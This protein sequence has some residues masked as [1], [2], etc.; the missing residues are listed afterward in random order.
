M[1]GPILRAK[2]GYSLQPVQTRDEDLICDW[3]NDPTHSHLFLGDGKYLSK[4]TFKR[5]LRRLIR[6]AVF[7][8]MI[9]E[10][11]TQLRVGFIYAYG[12]S[13]TRTSCSVAVFVSD[14][15]R[16]RGVGPIAFGLLA[17]YL[18]FRFPFQK[19]KASIAGYNEL[20]LKTARH[21]SFIKLEGVEEREL[22]LGNELF[23]FYHLAHYREDFP[24][25]QSEPL[26][27][28]LIGDDGGEHRGI[29]AVAA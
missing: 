1:E 25:M 26:W 3:K 28:R 7:A 20:S 24:K 27:K 23:P 2:A 18:F 8:A 29:L 15:C 12:Q 19:L 14:D 6:N 21:Y 5:K 10:D 4:R 22:V 13:A 9:V 11:A 16:N 17:R